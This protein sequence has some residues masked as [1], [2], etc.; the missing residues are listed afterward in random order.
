MQQSPGSPL[1]A[2][3][4]PA[5]PSLPGPKKF[6]HAKGKPEKCVS[7]REPKEAAGSGRRLATRDLEEEGR[8]HFFVVALGAIT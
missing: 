5:P 8:R 7:E 6:Y 1:R 3:Q 4:H 2:Q